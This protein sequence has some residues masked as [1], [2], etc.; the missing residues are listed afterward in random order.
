[1]FSSIVKKQKNTLFLKLCNKDLSEQ[2][3]NSI[4]TDLSKRKHCKELGIDLGSVTVFK[5]EFFEFLNKI[6]K[7]FK[8]SVYNVSSDNLTLFYLMNYNRFVNLFDNLDDYM[9][10]KNQLVKRSFFVCR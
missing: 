10:N 9:N 8:I 6:G 4:C 3:L 1:M 7:T 2:A 5:N